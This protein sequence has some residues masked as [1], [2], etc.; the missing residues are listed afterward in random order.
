MT[1]T[2]DAATRML[3]ASAADPARYSSV[4]TSVAAWLANIYP[5]LRGASLP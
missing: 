2:F 1:R 5:W 3:A 4:E